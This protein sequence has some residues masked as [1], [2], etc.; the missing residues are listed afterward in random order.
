MKPPII[1]A[2]SSPRRKALLSLL[3]IPFTVKESSFDESFIDANSP[4]Y[5]AQRIAQGKAEAVAINNPDALVIG[6]DTFIFFNG[7]KIGKAKHRDE[8]R[9]MLEDFS[10]N[11]HEVVTG[12]A[13]IWKS[14]NIVKTF[15]S[16][17][18]VTFRTLTAEEIDRYLDCGEFIDKAGAY[19]IQER[20]SAF[21]SHVEGNTSGIVGLPLS[22]LVVALR[23][24]GDLI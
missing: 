6:A 12:V 16:M 19:A 23:E 17:S 9:N 18:R 11:T 3:D 24:I 10:G 1:L 20:A 4:T 22:D 5:E 14:R 15:V 13:L 2:S 8:A 21:V 7:Q